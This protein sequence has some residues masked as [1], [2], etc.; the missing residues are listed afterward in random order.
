MSMVAEHHE[1]GCSCVRLRKFQLASV[2]LLDAT[3]WNTGDVVFAQG[4]HEPMSQDNTIGGFIADLSPCALL[5]SVKTAI[6]GC[7]NDLLHIHINIIHM[8]IKCQRFP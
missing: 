7:P 6:S 2:I 3:G 4:K 8:C 1:V 5:I